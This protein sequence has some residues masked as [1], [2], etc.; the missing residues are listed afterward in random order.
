[1]AR[2][3]LL[4]KSE[5]QAL[6]DPFSK[7]GA[8][9]LFYLLSRSPRGSDDPFSVNELARVLELSPNTVHRSVL[10][11]EH[12]G[13]VKA[14]GLRTSKRFTLSD[15]KALLV[16]WLRHY[17]FGKK[18][19]IKQFAISDPSQFKRTLEPRLAAGEFVPALHTAAREVFHTGVMNLGTHEYYVLSWPMRASLMKSFTLVEQDRGYEVLLVQPYYQEV[20]RRF[21]AGKDQEI[22]NSALAILTFL[23]LFH[24]PLRGREQAESLFRKSKTLSRLCS[25]SALEG[26]L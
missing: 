2:H 13:I 15:P 12:E 16:H 8:L 5:R 14:Q 22:W 24:F 23:D 19:K 18:S 11:L 25:W 26:S 1:M 7:K 17:S 6:A 21:A 10:A 9:A 20:V 4:P 3:G